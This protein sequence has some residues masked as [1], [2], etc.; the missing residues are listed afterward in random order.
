MLKCGCKPQVD[1]ML[2]R[3]DCG[4]SGND[5]AQLQL[6]QDRRLSG[7]IE[8]YHQDSHLLLAPEAIEQPRECDTHVGGV[9]AIACGWTGMGG[10]KWWA[11]CLRGAS[12]SYSASSRLQCCGLR[13]WIECMH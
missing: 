4:N 5:F 3:T 11:V 10:R 6:V 1:G 12:V 9:L 8:A 7:G 13:V 2:E